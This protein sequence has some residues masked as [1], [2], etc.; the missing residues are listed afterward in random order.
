MGRTIDIAII[1]LP[2]ISNFDDFDPL[3]LEAGVSVRYVSRAEELGLPDAAILPGSKATLAD[4]DW[5]RESGLDLGLAW[6]ARA[7]RSVLGICGGF[8][9]L[10]SSIDDAE[11][12]EGPP[13]SA[14]GLGLLPLR[15]VF[16]RDKT[17]LPRRGSVIGGPGFLASAAGAAVAGYEI[18][19]GRTYVEGRGII[20]LDAEGD[21]PGREDGAAAEGGRVWGSYLHGL[22]D[23]PG[24]RGAWL[25]S[26][27]AA[28]ADRGRSFAAEREKALDRLADAVEANLDLG[29]VLARAGII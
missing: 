10:G 15:T 16:G 5:L 14:P 1:A 4:L 6:L 17:A 28:P 21:L 24:L 18:H 25:A 22:F 29:P 7:G 12:I 19:A 2:R 11:G 20:R 13:R 9:M 8:Q 26:L 27:G 3:R 23:L